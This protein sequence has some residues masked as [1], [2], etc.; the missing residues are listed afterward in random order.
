MAG[1]IGAFLGFG[2][3]RVSGLS[4][5]PLLE[6]GDFILFHRLAATK[7]PK[8][9]AIV[10]VHHEHL[11]TIVKLLGEETPSGRFK[12]AGLSVVSTEAAHLGQVKRQDIVGQA[13]VRISRHSVSPLWAG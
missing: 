5:R 6:E 1:S 11:G 3:V 8:P 2:I 9:G 4:M 12:L 7:V 10:I 13:M